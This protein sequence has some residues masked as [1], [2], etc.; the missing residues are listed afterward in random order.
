MKSVTDY[1]LKS[2]E[3]WTDKKEH[4]VV[5]KKEY[6]EFCKDYIFLKLKDIP[7]GKAFCERFD[8]HHF[9]IASLPGDSAKGY[10]EKHGFV[11]K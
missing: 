10:V 7:F 8:I 5:S 1:F 3:Q 11:K 9:I 2:L 4:K 6:E